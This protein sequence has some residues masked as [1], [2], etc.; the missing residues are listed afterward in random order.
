MT[1]KTP[2]SR[3]DD[4]FETRG[5]IAAEVARRRQ[6]NDDSFHAPIAEPDLEVPDS[7][8]LIDAASKRIQRINWINR[9]E[10][11]NKIKESLFDNLVIRD[12]SDSQSQDDYSMELARQLEYH[13]FQG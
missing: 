4:K 6:N 12:G 1:E 2:F 11:L 10:Y 3:T 5:I 7:C 9:E 13:I 8:R